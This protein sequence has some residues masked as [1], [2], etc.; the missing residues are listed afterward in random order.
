M[1]ERCSVMIWQATTEG[2]AQEVE[3]KDEIVSSRQLGMYQ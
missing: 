1:L 3:S 2:V